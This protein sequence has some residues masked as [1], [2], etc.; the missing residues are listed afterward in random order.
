MPIFG[1]VITLAAAPEARSAALA[2]LAREPGLTLGSLAGLRLPV[3]LE[4]EPETCHETRVA[5]W[6]ALAGVVHV[7]YAFADFDDLVGEPREK[8]VAT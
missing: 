5:S 4:L 7:D 3:A 1:F 2:E 8:E 6:L